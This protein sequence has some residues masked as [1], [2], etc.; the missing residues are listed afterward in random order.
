[1]G[2]VLASNRASVAEVR[3]DQ[4]RKIAPQIGIDRLHWSARHGL[5]LHAK[6]DDFYEFLVPGVGLA[7][8]TEFSILITLFAVVVGPVNFYVLRQRKRLY[9]LLLSVPLAAALVTAALL[10]YA[11]IGE[12]LGVRVRARSVTH[13]D[14]RSGEA[15]TWARLS[16][17]AGVG[18]SEGLRFSADTAVLPIH[19][20]RHDE[21]EGRRAV[22]WSED[23]HLAGNWLPARSP[24]QFLTIRPHRSSGR[25]NVVLANSKPA[26]VENA[27]GSAVTHVAVFDD[28]GRPFVAQNVP[29]GSSASL[30]A[31]G[32]LKPIGEAL[33][34]GQSSKQMPEGLGDYQT[35]RGLFEMRSR[36]WYYYGPGRFGRGAVPAGDTSRLERVL[37]TLG[38]SKNALLDT[39][40]HQ[41]RTYVAIVAESP[42][43]A[44]GLDP[45]EEEASFHVIVGKW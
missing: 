13:L 29:P 20:F 44:F 11:A 43:V 18:P 14:Q 34:E 38:G 40:N 31:D 8:V 6:N 33:F 22:H 9:L 30:E 12:G 10:A 45:V 1:M 37:A 16:Y 32:N 3:T 25:L 19:A 15:V 4:W 27:L 41:P 42:E 36:D 2:Q 17:Y 28:E 39:K 35:S 21:T 26:R 24:T 23:Q 7:P 5:T